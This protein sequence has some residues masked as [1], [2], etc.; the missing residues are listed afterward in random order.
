MEKKTSQSRW[1]NLIKEKKH[2]LQIFEKRTNN[3]TIGQRNQPFLIMLFISFI[4]LGTIGSRLFFL[5]LI[6]GESY[7]NKAE[8]NSVRIMPKPPIKGKV[9][10]FKKIGEAIQRRMDRKTI[11]ATDPAT[12]RKV[13]KIAPKKEIDV[14]KGKMEAFVAEISDKMKMNYMKKAAKQVTNTEKMRDYALQQMD[15][16]PGSFSKSDN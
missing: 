8:K 7:R 9:G 1:Q 5:Q 12:G 14:G 2:S 4:L 13:V 11:I 15:K 6:E 3:L 16:K 10:E